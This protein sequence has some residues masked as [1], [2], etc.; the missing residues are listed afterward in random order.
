MMVLP[1]YNENFGNV[2][3]EAMGER[4]PVVVTPEVGAADVV[5]ETGAGIVVDGEPE[6][7]GA[8]I[9]ELLDDPARR[10]TMGE[11]GAHGHRD[12]LLVA[13]DRRAGR[14]ALPPILEKRKA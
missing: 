8:G 3:L 7:L 5:R 10:A 2:V 13:R 9:R 6:I 1:S 14:S 11:A 12:A 4:C